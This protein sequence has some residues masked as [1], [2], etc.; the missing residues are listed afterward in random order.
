MK[1]FWLLFALG[2][3]VWAGDP[4][5]LKF[6]PLRPVS[7]PHVETCTLSNG[8]RLYLLEDHELPV[9]SGL[10]LV[11]TGNLFELPDKV[12]LAT[13]TG[14]LMRSGGA[15]AKTGNQLDEALENIAASV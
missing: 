14:I 1:R 12:G 8:L 2:A 4:L 10:A 7:I 6:P 3:L 11:R 15:G 9:V 13:V 5:G